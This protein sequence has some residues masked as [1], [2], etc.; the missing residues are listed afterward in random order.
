M[1]TVIRINLLYSQTALIIAG[2][3]VTLQ[4]ASKQH[5]YSECHILSL[6]SNTWRLIIK[7]CNRNEPKQYTNTWE[8]MEVSNSM[9][10]HADNSSNHADL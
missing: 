2:P 7:S 9:K 6:K 1:T 3:G 10:E 5:I 4:N 8:I